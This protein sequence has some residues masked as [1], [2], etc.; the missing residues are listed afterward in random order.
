MRGDTKLED[1]CAWYGICYLIDTTLGL[2]L[3][4]MFLRVQDWFAIRYNLEGLKHNGLYSGPHACQHWT[5]QTLAWIINLTLVKI[6]IYEFM[7]IFSDALAIFGGILFAPIQINIRFELLFV[8][9]FFPGFLNVIYFWIADS[10][11]KAAPV[12]DSDAFEPKEKS[13]REMALISEEDKKKQAEYD[14]AAEVH[15]T[16]SQQH[17]QDV[18]T[19]TDWGRHSEFI[20]T[21]LPAWSVF[22]VQAKPSQEDMEEVEGAAQQQAAGVLSSSSKNSKDGVIV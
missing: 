18:L 20:S 13:D 1:D 9:I 8:M 3:A 21:Y 4:I 22:G 17:Q 15:L 11:L 7:W 6:L 2:V 12:E 10:Y 14:A 19:H 5:H 16:Q